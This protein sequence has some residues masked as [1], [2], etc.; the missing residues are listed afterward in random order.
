MKTLLIKDLKTMSLPAFAFLLIDAVLVTIQWSEASLGNFVVILCLPIIAVYLIFAKDESSGWDKYVNALPCT[1]K[2]IVGEK[3][4]VSA[5]LAVAME[6]TIL[7]F[8]AIAPLLSGS[9][10]YFEVVCAASV[11]VLF[12]CLTLAIFIPCAVSFGVIKGIVISVFF[13][14]CIFMPVFYACYSSIG[15]QVNYFYGGAY[16]STTFYGIKSAGPMILLF[17]LCN[18][19]GF[20]SLLLSYC[21]TLRFFQKRDY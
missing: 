17:W 18:A 7:F 2:E 8:G 20:I 9:T 13:C 4:I 6:F 5:L 11:S 3:F 19:F 15:T 12:V 1:E 14:I 21:A 16:V 10:S